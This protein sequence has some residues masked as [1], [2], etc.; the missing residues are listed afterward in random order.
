M[1]VEENRV[2]K[3]K[4]NNEWVKLT[5]NQVFQLQKVG[6]KKVSKSIYWVCRVKITNIRLSSTQVKIKI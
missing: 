4:V 1:I 2:S 5:A 6:K 3:K